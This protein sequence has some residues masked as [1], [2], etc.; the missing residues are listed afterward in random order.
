MLSPSTVH[1]L[2]RLL[3]ALAWLLFLVLLTL[4]I[5]RMLQDQYGT[6]VYILAIVFCAPAPIAGIGLWR[7]R[8]W[9]WKLALLHLGL[10]FL[11]FR[12]P[13]EMLV[14]GF[15]IAFLLWIQRPYFALSGD[16]R[17]NI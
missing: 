11:V 8:R 7:G 12:S 1:L 6:S 14:C 17:Q 13:T 9:G 10:A 15:V 16:A 5:P 3:A 2:A 4:A